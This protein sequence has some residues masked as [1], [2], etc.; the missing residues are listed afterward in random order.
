MTNA[1]TMQPS[2]KFIMR[3]LCQNVRVSTSIR[4]AVGANETAAEILSAAF[5]CSPA[6]LTAVK[7]HISHILQKFKNFN[8]RNKES[9]NC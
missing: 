7:P 3:R 2:K 4:G 8:I 6:R 1:K 5:A 9:L